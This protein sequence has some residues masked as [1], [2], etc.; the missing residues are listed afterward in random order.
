[1]AR[2]PF[3]WQVHVRREVLDDEVARLRELPYSVWCD[4]VRAPM[5]KKAL[6]RDNRTYRVRVSA[7]W[8]GDGTE[9]IRVTAS[10]QTR[11]LRRTIASESFVV[12]PEGEILD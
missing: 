11:G 5:T 3:V 6:G 12:T 4:V 9:D 7:A 2:D 8:A 1:M 10:L